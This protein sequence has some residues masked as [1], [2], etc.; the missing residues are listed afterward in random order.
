MLRDFDTSAVE[1]G[2]WLA[3]TPTAF[4]EAVLARSDRIHLG[5]GEAL[6]H[7]GDEAGGLYGVAEGIVEAHLHPRGDAPTLLHLLG[8]G[9]WTGEFATATGQPRLIALIARSQCR[10]LRLSR[11]EFQRLAEEDPLAWQFLAH[12][13]IGNLA[14]TVAVITALRQ[15]SAPARLALTLANLA[16]ETDTRPPMLRLSQA[17][18]GIM[19]QMS[20]GAVNAALARLEHAGLV[21][22]DYGAI[23]VLDVNALA[24]F[25]DAG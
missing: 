13:A 20:R 21:R 8:P 17:E 5:P 14:R 25:E 18:L 7:A 23:T 12:L 1:T 15:H 11:A 4:R 24:A 2:G 3:R 19:A 10:I 22:R 9:F 16:R 6:Y